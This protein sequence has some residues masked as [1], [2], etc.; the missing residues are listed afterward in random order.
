MTRDKEDN[1]DQFQYVKIHRKK[2]DSIRLQEITTEF[3]GII[4]WSVI[5][6]SIVLG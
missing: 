3:V 1:I 2:I 4:P 5:L 6:R